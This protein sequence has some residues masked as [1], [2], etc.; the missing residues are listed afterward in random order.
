MCKCTCLHVHVH[1]YCVLHVC[2]HWWRAVMGNRIPLGN[3]WCLGMAGVC[4][5]PSRGCCYAQGLSANV[6][7]FH[8]VWWSPV[9]ALVSAELA[10]LP[11]DSGSTRVWCPL[12]HL[13]GNG[14]VWHSLKH[15]R[16]CLMH[17][18]TSHTCAH[19]D[20]LSLVGPAVSFPCRKCRIQKIQ[21]REYKARRLCLRNAVSVSCVFKFSFFKASK[22]P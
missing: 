6:A 9:A 2:T 22:V 11:D 10:W 7:P 14:S 3:S 15:E 19:R 20:S 4:P 5:G 21:A 16:A 1:V 18:L 8:V 12:Q 17:T 13:L